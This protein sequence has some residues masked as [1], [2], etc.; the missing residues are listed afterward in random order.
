MSTDEV[1]FKHPPATDVQL[2]VAFPNNFEVADQRNR[3][4]KLVRAD[5]PIL[6]MPEQ[7]KMTYD[8]ADYMLQR[9]DTAERLEIGMNYFRQTSLR[10][11]GFRKFRESFLKAIGAFSECYGLNSFTQLS[12]A[13]RNILPLENQQKYQDIFALKISLP[14]IDETELFAGQGVVVFQNPQGFVTV[15]LEPKIEGSQIKSYSMNLIFLTRQ[16]NPSQFEKSRVVE[17]AEMAHDNLK[18][19][20]FAI[21]TKQYVEYLSR[22]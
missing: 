2:G 13:Y 4:Y 9:Q 8:F 19:Y 11:P 1:I 22:R 16:D 21:L 10:Y 20:F 5:F 12:M 17:F 7:N 18:R 15:Q 14:E 6:V 3:F